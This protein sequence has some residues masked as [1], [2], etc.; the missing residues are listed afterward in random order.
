MADL[1]L[2]F[3]A[4]NHLQFKNWPF[5]NYSMFKSQVL[6]ISVACGTNACNKSGIKKRKDLALNA[7]MNLT[8]IE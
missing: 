8:V 1:A 3:K 4:E 2:F 7:G 5:F 6:I